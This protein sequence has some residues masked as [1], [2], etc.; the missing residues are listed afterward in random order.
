VG[1]RECSI[2]RRYQKII[3]ESP[4]PSVSPGDREELYERTRRIVK[5]IGYTGV[6]TVEFLKGAGGYYF[7]EINAR[8]QVEH[9]VSE[10]VTGLDIVEWQIRTSAGE[11][12]DF[13]QDDVRLRGHAIECR[14]YA[15]DPETFVPSPGTITKLRLPDGRGGRV[16]V[17]H[18]LHE[19]YKVSPFYD[20]MLCKVIAWGEDRKNCIG[21]MREALKSMAV[22]GVSTSIPVGV[23]VMEAPQFI[24]GDFST[25]FFD[26]V[27][28]T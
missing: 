6:G 26:A 8:L 17:D 13:S 25:D 23:S 11:T 19:G 27:L 22:E 14:I 21:L 2:Q 9:P 12:L 15:E 16:R 10:M 18:A 28:A 7:M 1:E 24:S 20:S 5:A 4:S 3:E